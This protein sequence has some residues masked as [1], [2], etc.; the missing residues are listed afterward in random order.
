MFAWGKHRERGADG[1]YSM[2]DPAS[3]MVAAA[4]AL[5]LGDVTRPDEFRLLTPDAFQ[6]RAIVDEGLMVYAEWR[7]IVAIDRN[8]LR[9]ETPDIGEDDLEIQT[10]SGG[11]LRGEVFDAGLQRM[12][13]FSTSLHDGAVTGGSSASRVA[14]DS[15]PWWKRG[16]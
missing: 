13:P 12:V 7:R 11:V 15:R 6:V 4:G 10:V 8:G 9:W 14:P 3:I 2:P 5:Y 16:R 1:V